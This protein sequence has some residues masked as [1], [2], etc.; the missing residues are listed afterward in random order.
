MTG[1]SPKPIGHAIIRLEEVEST[2]TL[3]MDT[4]HYLDNHGLVVIA[5]HQSGGRG[6]V[7]RKWASLPGTQLQ[8][9]VVLHP[10]LS[11]EEVPVI[12]LVAGL[13]VGKSLA[14][15]PGLRPLLKWPNDVFLGPGKVCGILVEMKVAGAA[16]RVV[17]GIGLNCLGAPR[18]FPPEVRALVTTVSHE[19]G[20]PVDME[21][22]FAD[23]LASLQR[24]YDR[25]VAG[26]K[27]ALL[28]EW[29]A[30]AGLAGRPL[31]YPA[32]EGLLPGKALGLTEEGYLLIETPSG[33][34]HVHASGELE[35][36]D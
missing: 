34:T 2:N 29:S 26:Q 22:L 11:R 8:F 25:L 33:A 5:A 35:W 15:L 1:A 32:P 21:R 30:M 9:S 7:G 36:T 6:R 19:T 3:V 4:P 17:V 12:S 16:P 13:A 27:S 14:V 31:R 10:P 23:V 24:E 18:D 20:G 28:D